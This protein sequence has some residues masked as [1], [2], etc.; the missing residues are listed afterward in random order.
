LSCAEF[1]DLAAAVALGAADEEDTRRVQEHARA[2]PECG[3]HLL[4]FDEVAAAIGTTVPQLDPP[5]IVKGRLFEVVSHTPQE[6]RRLLPFG[7]TRARLSAAWLVAAASFVVSLVAIGWAASIQ[8]QLIALQNQAVQHPTAEFDRGAVRALQPVS[9][10]M[11]TRGIVYLDS[12]SGTGMVMCHGLPPI[13]QGHA[14]QIWFVRGTERVSG[15]MLWPDRFGDGYT[16]IQVPQDLQSFESIG[17][18]DEPGT[19]SAWPTT[20]RVIGTP[21]K[22]STQ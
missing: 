6:R 9:V 4:D 7:V 18:T 5:A 1:L 17:L 14:Y 11:P 10:N 22:E 8:T 15:G 20:P 12:T 2:C 3:K 21:L 13:E 16:L 19:G